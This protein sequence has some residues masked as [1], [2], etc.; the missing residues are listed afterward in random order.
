MAAKASIP[1]EGH[2]VVG[3]FHDAG[4]FVTALEALLGAGFDRATISVLADRDAIQDH[5]GRI[6]KAETLAERADTPREDLDTEGALR[7]AI[8]FIAETVAVIGEI[9]AAGI[10]FAV[11]GPV[12][13]ASGAATAADLS[14]GDVLTRYVDR[15]YHARF[16]QSVRDGGVIAWVHVSE[17]KAAAAAKE[18]LAEHGGEDV[19]EVDL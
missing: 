9:G 12:G 18:T 10:A 13:I 19:H 17:Q 8:R 2:F 11:G 16:E 14:V 6:P 5:F 3:I 1:K 7:G 15:D 4:R